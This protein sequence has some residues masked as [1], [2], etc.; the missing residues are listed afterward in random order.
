MIVSSGTPFG[1]RRDMAGGELAVLIKGVWGEEK[2]EE[3]ERTRGKCAR[4]GEE[5]SCD[6]L[7]GL[8]IDFV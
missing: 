8:G 5:S 4:S 7:G 6:F 1:I 3:M 2:K